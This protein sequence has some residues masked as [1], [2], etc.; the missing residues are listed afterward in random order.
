MSSI[1]NK[2]KEYGFEC[3]RQNMYTIGK[4]YGFIKEV[5]DCVHGKYEFDKDIFEKWLN[6]KIKG[7]DI[8]NGYEPMSEVVGSMDSC[9]SYV[10]E[11][12]KMNIEGSGIIKIGWRYYVNREQAD[13]FIKSH[14]ELFKEFIERYDRNVKSETK[15]ERKQFDYWGE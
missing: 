7:E 3:S 2:C 1:L 6:G 14:K 4:K 5:N 9:R 15:K 11:L 10:Y 8:P 12:A 13:E